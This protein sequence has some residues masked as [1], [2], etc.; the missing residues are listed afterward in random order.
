[1]GLTESNTTVELQK[2]EKA[3]LNLPQVNCPVTHTFSNG[4]YIR[5]MLAPKGTLA[6]GHWHKTTH[7]NIILKG[8]FNVL[9]ADGTVL[10]IV[11]PCTFISPP[12]R[13][14]AYFLEETVWQN[15]HI[16]EE[17]DIEK[18]EE[19]FIE[20]SPVWI[21]DAELKKLQMEV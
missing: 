10:G 14:I 20:K 2:T 21:E 5:E 3:M 8:R 1:M 16:T 13:K 17:T 19:L 11:A 18:I 15:I 9:Q 12:G 7:I 6:M 4:H